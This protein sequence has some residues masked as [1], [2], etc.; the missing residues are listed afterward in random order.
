MNIEAEII[1]DKELL[2]DFCES[3]GF[4]TSTTNRVLGLL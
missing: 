4:D 1:A 3:K 2:R